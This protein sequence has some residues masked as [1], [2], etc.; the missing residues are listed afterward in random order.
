MGE[1]L[2]ERVQEATRQ[3]LDRPRPAPG[4]AAEGGRRL[5]FRT[6][7][8]TWS[9]RIE[10]ELLPEIPMPDF[11]GIAL[12]RPR[13]EPSDEEVAARRW[14]GS[15]ARNA[16]LEDV[17]EDRPAAKGDTVVADFVGRLVEGEGEEAARRRALPGRQRDRHADRGGRRGLHPR[18]HRGAG[19]HPRRRDPQGA[20]RPSPRATRTAEL[21]GK[22]AEFEMTAKALK[23][24]A[25]APVDDDFAKYLGLESAGEAAG[26][27]CAPPSSAS[28][29][30]SPG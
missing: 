27:S 7:A 28:T 17:T 15:R 5:Q 6:M 21:A 19:G 8:R 23:T 13:A 22:P 20:R 11:S 25:A 14:T 30:S 2:E 29:T 3:M 9:S 4:P 10:L 12:E 1:V 16:K 18:L 26:A 24:R